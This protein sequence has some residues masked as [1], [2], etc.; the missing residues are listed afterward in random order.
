MGLHSL[1]EFLTKLDS[2]G[3]KK[4]DWD[5]SSGNHECPENMK[6]LPIVSVVIQSGPNM[7]DSETKLKVWCEFV[8]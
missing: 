4:S 7:E 8:S 3:M 5:L 6:I 1:S 2:Q